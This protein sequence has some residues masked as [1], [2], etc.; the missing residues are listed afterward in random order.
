MWGG[1]DDHIEDL[2]LLGVVEVAALLDL[3]E[4]GATFQLAVSTRRRGGGAEND[5]RGGRKYWKRPRRRCGRGEDAKGKLQVLT[6]QGVGWVG[7]C[8][9]F[10][11]LVGFGP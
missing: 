6:E 8:L 3:L 2:I 1:D 11:N 9:V 7:Y 10:S 5:M 4:D